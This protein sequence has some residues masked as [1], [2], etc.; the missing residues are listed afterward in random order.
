MRLWPT[1]GLIVL[2]LI[3][4]PLATGSAARLVGQVSPGPLTRAHGEL[5]GTL[6]CTKCHGGGKEAMPARCA[7]CHKDIGWLQ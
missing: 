6:K 4:G 5:E 7:S 3:L 2:S 1:G